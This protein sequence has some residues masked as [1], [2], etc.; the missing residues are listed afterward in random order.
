MNNGA[1]QPSDQESVHS[2]AFLVTPKLGMREFELFRQLILDCSG[3]TLADSKFLLMQNRIGRR[4]RA[5]GLSSFGQYYRY[6]QTAEGGSKELGN[7]WSA[8]TT[9]ETHFFREPQHFEILQN[10][11][12]PGLVSRRCNNHVLRVWSAGCSTGQEAYTLAMVL[13]KWL[14]QK[15][16]WSF[17]VLG[18]DIDGQALETARAGSYPLRLK[19]EIP[20]EYLIRYVDTSAGQMRIRPTLMDCVHFRIH[21]FAKIS[22]VRPRVDIVFC[23]NTLMY[24]HAG[25]RQK[26]ARVFR[27]SLTDGGYLTVGASESLNGSPRPL[28]RVHIGKVL[29]YRKPSSWES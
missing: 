2:N 12:L 17:S 10:S 19:S 28:E 3:I 20:E 24:L 7:L 29:I 16:G 13:D 25:T 22:P 23:R 1:M 26:L 8:I 27:D 15:P 14:S 9:K 11:L 21:N 18:S 6:L 4:L 5:L